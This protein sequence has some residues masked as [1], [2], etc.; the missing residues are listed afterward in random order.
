MTN[1]T[2]IAF[3]ADDNLYVTNSGENFVKFNAAGVYQGTVGGP[4]IGCCGP[5]SVA[6]SQAGDEYFFN[7]GGEIVVTDEA[8]AVVSRVR[9][10]AG[11]A[12]AVSEAL[13]RLYI[14]HGGEV[15][16]YKGADVPSSRTDDPTALFR[17]GATLNGTINPD[18]LGNA[19][20]KFEYGTD[21]SY[22]QSAPCSPAGP[23]NDSADHAVSAAV[24]GLASETEYHYRLASTNANGTNY[25]EDK[26]F[27]LRAVPGLLTK[28]ATDREADSVVL[29]GSFDPA[30]E[31]T[32]YFFEWGADS[33]YGN[34]IPALPGTLVPGSATG[35]QAASAKLEGLEI[36]HEYH[37][38][39]V[40]TNKYG[41]SYGE[42]RHRHDPAGAAGGQCPAGH[43]GA[44]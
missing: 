40:A 18:G 41:T 21:T 37:Y 1:P 11:G 33:S 44:R 14:L 4:S 28:P 12:I 24:T 2:S 34:T 22:G 36:A 15:D 27:L 42:D 9:P 17:P 19:T 5:N 3:D 31:D 6:I 26:T 23:F 13:R 32:R 30:G 16:I 35:V 10:E 20:C 8:N 29:Q 7:Y 43:R 25:G 39:I 38:R